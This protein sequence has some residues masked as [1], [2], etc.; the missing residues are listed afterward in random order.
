MIRRKVTKL[1]PMISG[2]TVPDIT[3]KLIDTINGVNYPINCTGANVIIYLMDSRDKVIRTF[4]TGRGE[5]SIN[6][7]DIIIN[8]FVAMT[9]D[10]G[11]YHS[12]GSVI[13]SD[14]RLITNLFETNWIFMNR[15]SE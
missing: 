9:L 6:G 2:Q 3:Y 15:C 14:R 8:S 1:K 12:V 4:S 5:M 7:S 13:L 11:F 10:T